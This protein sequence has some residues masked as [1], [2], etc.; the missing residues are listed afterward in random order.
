MHWQDYVDPAAIRRTVDKARR[1]RLNVLL[2]LANYPDNLMY[3]SEILP[4]NK[5]VPRGFNPLPALVEAAHAAGL[6]VHPYFVLC[7]VGLTKVA[8]NRPDWWVCDL[9]GQPD[10]GWA[11]P[12]NPEVR[13]FLTDLVTE[14]V[15]YGVDG[16]HLDYIRYS[17]KTRYCY[18]RDCRRRFQAEQGI[19]P[20]ALMQPRREGSGLYLL[21]S[22]FHQGKGAYLFKDIQR[23]VLSAGFSPP[24][25]DEAGIRKLPAQSVLIVSNL[26]RGRTSGTL[27]RDLLRY[28]RQGGGVVIL[29]GPQAVVDHRLFAEAVGLTGTAYFDTTPLLLQPVGTHPIVQGVAPIPLR[30]RGNPCPTVTTAQVLACF[31]NGRPA[32]TYKRYEKGHFVVLNYHCYQAESGEKEDVLRLLAQ[33]VDWL[34]EQNGTLNTTRLGPGG[35]R[36]K[37]AA[38][39]HWRCEQITG[40]VRQMSEAMRAIN[41][42]LIVSAAGGTRV[43]DKATLFR[44]GQTWLDQG[45]VHYLCPMLYT[46]DNNLFRQRLRSELEPLRPGQAHWLYAGIGAYKLTQNPRRVVEQVQLARQEGLNGVCFFSFEYL[47]ET[48]IRLL[49]EGPFAQESPVPWQIVRSETTF[50]SERPLQK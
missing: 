43:E 34:G 2:P 42:E 14:V 32:M 27:V 6:E 1:A 39:N 36:N 49:R 46:P 20:V 16:V 45:L 26:Y 7:N 47:S 13:A 8:H 31:D 37:L 33:A 3:R 4:L 11:D 22:K 23:F 15:P 41:P 21:Q 12:A 29:D 19:D 25:V 24:I 9:N 30:A 17:E 18:C 35:L 44:D 48:M 10:P 38:W 50:F 5:N 28:A 40:L